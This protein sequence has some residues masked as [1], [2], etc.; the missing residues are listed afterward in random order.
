MIDNRGVRQLQIAVLAV[1][2]GNLVLRL[3]EAPHGRRVAARQLLVHAG[4]V[5]PYV[6]QLALDGEAPGHREEG[7]GGRQGGGGAK[8]EGSQ[9]LLM[10]LLFPLCIYSNGDIIFVVA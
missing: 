9:H 4:V 5:V 8:Q 2:E 7:R 10:Y 6:Q 1:E 3:G